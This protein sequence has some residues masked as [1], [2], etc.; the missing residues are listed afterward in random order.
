MIRRLVD[1]HYDEFSSEPNAD[2][3]RF[4]LRESRTPRVLIEV[5]AANPELFREVLPTR[6]LLAEAVEGGQA[7]L[8]LELDKEQ[9]TEKQVDALYWQPLKQELEALRLARR[10]RAAE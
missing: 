2:R 7:T 6:P 9:A 1:A 8:Q 10:H 5:V 4:W 3:I